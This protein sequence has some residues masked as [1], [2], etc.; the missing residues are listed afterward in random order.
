VFESLGIE[1]QRVINKVGIVVSAVGQMSQVPVPIR[2]VIYDVVDGVANRLASTHATMS[3]ICVGRWLDSPFISEADAVA[4]THQ[5]HEFDG[6]LLHCP[7]S[8]MKQLMPLIRAS[9]RPCVSMHFRSADH[10]V[11]HVIYDRVHAI[12]LAI[13]R[14]VACGH[15]TIGFIGEDDREQSTEFCKSAMVREALA[16][17]GLTLSK[18][19]T[20]LV[21]NHDAL[22]FVHHKLED[23]RTRLPDAFFVGTDY[24]AMQVLSVFKDQ[25]IGIP[26]DVDLMSFDDLPALNLIRPLLSTIHVPR[27][28]IGYQ[29][30][31]MLISWPVHGQPP[32]SRVLKAK[33]MIRETCCFVS[34]TTT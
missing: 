28:E 23:K 19:H 21:K 4:L 2:H 6:L 10:R 24:I 25:G 14:L 33:E 1:Q 30:A 15:R 11:P 12:E 13:E 17:H 31:D 8:L 22:G 32:A 34:S 18:Q 3:F 9:K 20:W 26:H 27:Q 5:F 7:P 16:F 29:A